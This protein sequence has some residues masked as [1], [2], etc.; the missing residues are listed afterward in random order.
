MVSEQP[1]RKMV[2]QFSDAGWTRINQ[3]G[4]HAKW[5]C[6][7]GKHTFTLPEGHRTV[8]AGVVRKAMKALKEG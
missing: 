2:K 5:G 4:S 1:T 8:S 7:C 3:V 6:P